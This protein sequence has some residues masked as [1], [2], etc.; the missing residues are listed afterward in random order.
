MLIFRYQKI[1][2]PRIT[3]LM[4]ANPKYSN[5]KDLALVRHSLLVLTQHNCLNI[6]LPILDDDAPDYSRRPHNLTLYSINT[7]GVLNRLRI[8]KT[9]GVSRTLYGD[10]GMMVVEEFAL[11]GRLGMKQLMQDVV[12]RLRGAVEEG[13]ELDVAA[14]EAQIREVFERMAADR[15]VHPVGSLMRAREEEAE[16]DFGPPAKKSLLDG[17]DEPSG[18]AA[19]KA[20]AK[21]AAATPT[22]SKKGRPATG[23]GEKRKRG[24]VAADEDLPLELRMMMQ[25]S[26]D[27]GSEAAAGGLS[28][29]YAK[30]AEQ[31]SVATAKAAPKATGRGRKPK[32]S[33]A[34]T[35]M[36]SST[37][38]PAPAAPAMQQRDST[39]LWTFGWTQYNRYE[40]NQICVKVVAERMGK[41]AEA[42]VHYVLSRSIG[43]EMTAPQ[44]TTHSSPCR[45]SD[46]VS[47]LNAGSVGGR[48][49]HSMAQVRRILE[50][51]RCDRMS[52]VSLS[53]AAEDTSADDAAYIVNIQAILKFLK[54]KTAHSIVCEKFGDVSGRIFELLLDKKYLD[55]QRIGDLAIAPSREVRSRMYNMYKANFVDYIDVS[56]R[57]D[58]NSLSTIFLWFVDMVKYEDAVLDLVF[59]AIYNLRVR[60]QF[61]RDQRKDLLDLVHKNQGI[62][63]DQSVA[64][65]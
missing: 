39:A 49:D 42:I 33:A 8:P 30:L 50:V 53:R 26:A 20:A 46:I 45:L 54:Q 19:A 43:V 64:Q 58:F 15:F 56:K 32:L 16:A 63:L 51:M 11:H 3:E 2:L 4:K 17:L 35:A 1:P 6:E 55:Q 14:A 47:S 7:S 52:V 21:K 41:M 18:S 10:I 24:A 37:A 12:A 36:L 9:I 48:T 57:A 27:N 44:V 40:R 31:S 59:K 61:E 60:S 23:A 13:G 62:N 29:K 22:T 25:A 34:A 65:R 38:T 5:K 28:S